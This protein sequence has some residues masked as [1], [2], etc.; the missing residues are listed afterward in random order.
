MLK[1]CK[2]EH[3]FEIRYLRDS[4]KFYLESKTELSEL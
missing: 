2:D 3:I 4:K 1:I